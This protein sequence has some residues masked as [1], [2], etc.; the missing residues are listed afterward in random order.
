VQ[1]KQQQVVLLQQLSLGYLPQLE[2]RQVLG[3]ESGI[4]LLQ[5]V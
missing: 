3:F 2:G 5:D 4:H 1:L